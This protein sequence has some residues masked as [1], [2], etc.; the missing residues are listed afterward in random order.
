[1]QSGTLLIKKKNQQQSHYPEK[2]E[3]N[4]L[5]IIKHNKLKC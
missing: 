1:M 5:V 2:S 4:T 3:T